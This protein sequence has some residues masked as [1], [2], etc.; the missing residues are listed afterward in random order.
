MEF[1]IS[2]TFLKAAAQSCIYAVLLSN[3]YEGDF[4]DEAQRYV[5]RAPLNKGD[6]KTGPLASAGTQRHQ[7]L[8]LVWLK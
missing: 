8:A 7:E 4:K 2:A 3:V 5:G 6:E 1:D